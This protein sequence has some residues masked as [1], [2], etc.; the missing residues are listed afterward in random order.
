MISNADIVETIELTAKLLE[1]HNDDEFKIK[2]YTNAAY[3]LDKYIGE[4]GQLDFPQLTQIQGVGKMIAGKI[5]EIVSTGQLRDLQELLA[6]TPEGVIEMFKIKGLGVKKIKILGNEL[7]LDN[8][9]DLQ[10]AC[11]N[12]SI[13]QVKGFGG[14]TQ[15]SILESL[16]FIQSQAG[17]LRMDKAAFLAEVI[18]VE[19]E[20]SFKQEEISRQIRRKRET[21]DNRLF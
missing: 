3:N 16:K 6:K 21:V 8:L 15:E 4:L 20:K 14:K 5:L 18:L 19:L 2:A 7:G 9:N 12:G 10:I 11:E 1:L 17:K 13:S